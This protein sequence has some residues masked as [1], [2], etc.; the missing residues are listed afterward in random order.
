MSRVLILAVALALGV[1]AYLLLTD[2]TAEAP[3]SEAGCEAEVAE[4]A[5]D[6]TPD[7]LA[8]LSSLERV[9]DHPMY[10]MRYVGT[11]RDS[12]VSHIES[13]RRAAIQGLPDWF[14]GEPYA[15]SLFAASDEAG[16][17]MVGR[18]FDWHY[19]PVLLL[20]TDPPDAYASMSF[21]DLAYFVPE[22]AVDSLD[23]ATI[24]DR[25]GLLETP[26]LPFDGMNE[27][28][29]MIGMAAVPP[30]DMPIDPDKVTRGSIDIIRDVLDHAA[31]VDE[32]VDRLTSVNVEMTGG[33]HIH[34]LVADSQ[35]AAAVVELAD[36][37]AYVLRSERPWLYMTNFRLSDMAE[38]TRA[39]TC[40]RYA[41]IGPTLEGVH[42]RLTTEAAMDLLE[43]VQQASETEPMGTLWSAVYELQERTVHV[44][45]KANFDTIHT[46][47][48]P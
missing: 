5:R 32:A 37:K 8:T 4:I 1:V 9:D 2:R 48:M 14:E 41:K 20:F 36:G 12:A 33:P 38:A 29:L 40:W 25:V 30:A 17:P 45:V 35:G 18:N 15:C 39:E 43:S 24:E 28:G 19:H 16:A 23:E 34:Y 13:P 31:T 3:A 27:Q 47:S 21:V 6:L 10:V 44:A 22:E 7:Q 46:F 42:G 11:Y 26:F